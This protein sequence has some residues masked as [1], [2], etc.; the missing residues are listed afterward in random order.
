M[1]LVQIHILILRVFNSANFNVFFSGS[2]IAQS[3]NSYDVDFVLTKGNK[4]E[5]CLLTLF[6][7]LRISSSY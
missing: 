6:S 2:K 4:T 7:P 1:K 3:D 5:I